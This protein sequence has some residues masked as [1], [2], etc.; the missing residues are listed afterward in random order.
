MSRERIFSALGILLAAAGLVVAGLS[1]AA[2][3]TSMSH[4]SA[5]MTDADMSEMS[6]SEMELHSTATADAAGSTA[7]ALLLAPWASTVSVTIAD[8]T[9]Q[10]V[11]SG[12]SA[13]DFEFTATTSPVLAATVTPIDPGTIGVMLSGAPLVSSAADESTV[14]LDAATANPEPSPIVGV[15]LDGFPIYGARDIDGAVISAD[16]LDRCNGI[17]SAT[18]EFPDGIYHYVLLDAGDFVSTMPCFSGVLS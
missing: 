4:D 1:I 2:P 14:P 12:G 11:S 10:L 5:D 6:E 3:S 16:Q 7:D 15:A 9:I 18:P 13:Q 17:T 8:D